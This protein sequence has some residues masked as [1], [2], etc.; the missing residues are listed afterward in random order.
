MF[1]SFVFGMMFG[2]TSCFFSMI[3]H[4]VIINRQEK[5]YDVIEENKKKNTSSK[6]HGVTFSKQ[7]KK[8]M[9]IITHDKKQKCIGFFKQ[10]IDAAKSYNVV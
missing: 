7:S 2:G 1:Y 3:Y 6:F 9:A 10:E 8:W 4:F 5:N